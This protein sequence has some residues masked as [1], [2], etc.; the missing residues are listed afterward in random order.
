MVMQLKESDYNFIY[1]DLG[2]DQVVFYNSR[3]GALAVVHEAQY[4]QFKA[5]R[6]T[7]KEIEDTEF[8]NKLLKCGYLIS[9]SVDERFLIKTKMLLG[10]YNQSALSFT[11]APTMACNFRC[12]Y[13]FE[14]GHYNHHLMDEQ[15]QEKVLQFIKNRVNA[16]IKSISVTWFGGEPLLGMPIIERLSH[17]II[18][19]CKEKDVHYSAAIVTNGYLLTNK[20]AEILK[21]LQVRAAQITIDGPKEIHDKRRPMINGQGTYDIIMKNLVDLRGTL[22][23]LLRI[24]TDYN[25]VNFVDKVIEDL[26][27]NRLQDYVYPALALVLPENSSYEKDDCMSNALFSKENI[28]FV[29]KHALPIHSLYPRLKSNYCDADKYNGWIIDDFGNLYKC[30]SDI[31]VSKKSIGS[32]LLD[33]SFITK[34]ELLEAYSKFDLSSE[35]ECSKCKFLPICM[36]GCP[37]K[38]AEGKLLCTQQKYYMQEY[39]VKYAEMILKSS[40]TFQ[41][42]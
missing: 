8:L 20:T 4:Q 5:F 10:R 26:K 30:W 12:V 27:T 9:A 21:E 3:T 18:S 22:P 16:N 37:R 11:I 13:C 41:N 24:N 36:G 33:N 28:R 42:I 6:E 19:F 17:E 38:R 15:T 14:A 2:K 1:D 31:G 23:I 32:V 40:P 29:L 39:L 34:T 35:S 25:N 7:G